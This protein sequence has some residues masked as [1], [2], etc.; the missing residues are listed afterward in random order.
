[1]VVILRGS[2]QMGS[3]KRQEEQPI[4]V[5]NINKPFLI[6]KYLVIFDEYELFVKA[7]KRE[8]HGETVLYNFTIKINSI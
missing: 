1:M 8:L 5:V 2:F 7:Q 4:H 3:N 6:A